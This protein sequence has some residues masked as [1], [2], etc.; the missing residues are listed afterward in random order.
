MNYSLVTIAPAEYRDSINL[1]A[2]SHGYGPNSLSVPLSPDGNEP[3]THY[4]ARSWASSTFRHGYTTMFPSQLLEV[5]HIDWQFDEHGV[6]GSHFN[7][8]LE[9]HGLKRIEDTGE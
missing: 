5:C 8:M 9:T 3:A 7:T 2:E 1:V 6:G 4:G